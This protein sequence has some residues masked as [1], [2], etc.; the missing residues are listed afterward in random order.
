MSTPR[1][2]RQLARECHETAII[3]PTSTVM[4]VDRL[5]QPSN[6]NKHERERHM[7]LVLNLL[8]GGALVLLIGLFVGTTAALMGEN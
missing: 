2:I 4:M 1:G 6:P 5:V 7:T 8:A 3:L